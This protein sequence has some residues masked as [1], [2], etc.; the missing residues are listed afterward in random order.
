MRGALPPPLPAKD[1]GRRWPGT[2][3]A[4]CAAWARR[5]GQSGTAWNLHTGPGCA[6]TWMPARILDDVYLFLKTLGCCDCFIY[7]IDFDILQLCT[8][9]KILG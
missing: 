9:K 5:S 4:S 3:C 2:A 6:H 7:E 1:P 8:S